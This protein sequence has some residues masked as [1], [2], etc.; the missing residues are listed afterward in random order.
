VPACLVWR[1]TPAGPYRILHVRLDSGRPDIELMASIGHE[2][3]HAL[4]VLEDSSLRSAAAMYLFYTRGKDTTPRTFETGAAQST[5]D[6]VYREI[7]RS[8]GKKR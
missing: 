4:E 8:R 3:R 2:L 7:R 6:A 5:G 1:V